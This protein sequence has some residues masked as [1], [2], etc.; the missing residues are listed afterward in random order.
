MWA[1]LRVEFS[2]ALLRVEFS[3]ALLRSRVQSSACTV[4]ALLR[5]EFRV[6][7]VGITEG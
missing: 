4:C 3:V 6:Y 2:V 1:L 7:C 5:V